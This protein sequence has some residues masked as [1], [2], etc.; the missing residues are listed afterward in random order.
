MKQY[1]RKIRFW[2]LSLTWGL[3]TTLVGGLVMLIL[4]IFK[5]KPKKFGYTYYINIGK[6]WGGLELGAFFLTDR[7]DNYKTKCHEHGHCLQNTWMGPLF[8]FIVGI[9][10]ILR[11]WLYRFKTDK[12]RTIFAVLVGIILVVL[13]GI[14]PILG[15]ILNIIWLKS[16][17]WFVFSQLLRIQIWLVYIELP[18]FQNC[19]GALPRY[20]SIWTEGNATEVGTNLIRELEVRV[21]EQKIHE[22]VK[23][24]K[25]EVEKSS[26][27]II[28]NNPI[29]F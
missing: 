5:Y 28:K 24:I 6:N 12:N 4:I 23:E 17:G 19:R 25:V 11:Y 7:T 22:M 29:T 15:Y 3:P 9:P 27:D 26:K 21:N 16:F 13:G 18:K 2:V 10:S 1:L 8:P 14:L 20:D